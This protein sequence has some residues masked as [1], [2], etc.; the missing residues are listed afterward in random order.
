MEVETENGLDYVRS[1]GSWY[2]EGVEVPEDAGEEK[3]FYKLSSGTHWSIYLYRENIKEQEETEEERAERE[4]KEEL[5]VNKNALE[6]VAKRSYELRKEFAKS[7][8]NAKAKEKIGWIIKHLIDESLDTHI[9]FNREKME[10]II[11]HKLSEDKAHIK[12]KP[13]KHLFAMAYCFIDYSS[14]KCHNWRGPFY[15][16]NEEL[17]LAYDFL[18]EFGYEISD[19]EKALKDGTHELYR[20]QKNEQ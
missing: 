8:S 3:Y 5:E 12:E 11:G 19:E 14:L 6:R 13:E 17:N 20:R 16:E 7:V 4:R 18:K 1:Y 9:Y 15:E 10:E 2:G